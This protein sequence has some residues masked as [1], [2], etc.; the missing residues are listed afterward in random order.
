MPMTG[1]HGGNPIVADA[2]SGQR[3]SQGSVQ[4][5]VPF[6][7][8]APPAHAS[9]MS[10]DV[11]RANSVGNVGVAP[12]ESSA[13]YAGAGT[14][15]GGSGAG[16]VVGAPAIGKAQSGGNRVRFADE[17]HAPSNTH[18]FSMSG[19]ATGK[20]FQNQYITA[21]TQGR[22]LPKPSDRP[23]ESPY[24]SS[25]FKA[26]LKEGEHYPGLGDAVHFKE[27]NKQLYNALTND[28][29]YAH[30][31]ETLYPGIIKVSVQPSPSSVNV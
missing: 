21:N 2:V 8:V 11:P 24:Y 19:Q 9:K 15:V 28:A 18:N 16:G 23:L 29:G 4:Q 22:T 10:S 7:R 14:G 6:Q 17:V 5:S 3:I 27:A 13:R 1:T 25:S 12:A 30:Q 26:T 31:M 20:L